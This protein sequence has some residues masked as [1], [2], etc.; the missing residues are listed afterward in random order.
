MN[1]QYLFEPDT[2]YDRGWDARLWE[3]GTIESNPYPPFTAEHDQWR[4][5]YEGS[6]SSIA[7]WVPEDQPTEKKT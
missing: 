7:A 5:G 2:P 6:N 1:E 3:T 4:K